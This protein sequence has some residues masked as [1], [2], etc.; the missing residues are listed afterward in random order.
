MLLTVIVFFTQ[1]TAH[2]LSRY[3]PLLLDRL[4]NSLLQTALSLALPY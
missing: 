3:V 2:F 4:L 1:L